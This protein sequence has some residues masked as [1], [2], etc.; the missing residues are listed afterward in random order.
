MSLIMCSS[1]VFWI[2]YF[3]LPLLTF[4]PNFW[5][6]SP[7]AISISGILICGHSWPPNTLC[8]TSLTPLLTCQHF[9]YYDY[10]GANSILIAVGL[11][12]MCKHIIT[13]QFPS[14]LTVFDWFLICTFSIFSCFWNQGV[15]IFKSQY[16]Y[17]P[18]NM[19]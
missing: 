3:S 6:S 7:S 10:V 4:P 9:H 2:Q 18:K 5:C 13:C 8:S 1:Y 17:F 12:L 19:F 15:I 11:W 16:L 14:H